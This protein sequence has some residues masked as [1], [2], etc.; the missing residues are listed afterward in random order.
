MQR[1]ES[2][3]PVWCRGAEVLAKFMRWLIKGDTGACRFT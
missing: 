1:N 2:S 3:G